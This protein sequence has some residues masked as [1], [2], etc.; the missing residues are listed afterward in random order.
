MN[1]APSSPYSLR[2]VGLPYA[3]SKS[4]GE[5]QHGKL[6]WRYSAWHGQP[7]V[8]G[9]RD[10]PF[11]TL[12]GVRESARAAKACCERHAASQPTEHSAP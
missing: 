4:L 7:L 2:A 5:D 12:L 11:P 8:P 3:V 10:I 6:R 9:R 1:W